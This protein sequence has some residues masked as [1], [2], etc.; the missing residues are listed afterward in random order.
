MGLTL[1][2]VGI[3]AVGVHAA[4]VAHNGFQLAL[5]QVLGDADKGVRSSYRLQ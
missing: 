1:N 3:N 5:G 2:R 4:A